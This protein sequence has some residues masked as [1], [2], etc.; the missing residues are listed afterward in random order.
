MRKL[1]IPKVPFRT[2]QLSPQ[3]LKLIKKREPVYHAG[4]KIMYQDYGAG[5]KLMRFERWEPEP[6]RYA[7]S[8]TH[9][10]DRKTGKLIL[11]KHPTRIGRE[12]WIRIK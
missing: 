10:Y 9:I 2:R 4:G 12:R 8:S 11:V 7:W 1:Q 6:G 3:L 5:R